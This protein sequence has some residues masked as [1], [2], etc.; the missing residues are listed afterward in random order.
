MTQLAGLL[1]V[2]LRGIGLIASAVVIGGMGYCL[3]VLRPLDPLRSQL[4][5]AALRRALKWVMGAALALAACRT[6]AVLVLQPWALADA[7]GRWPIGEFLRTGYARA[8]LLNAI[9]A[10]ALAAIVAS[11][12]RDPRSLR[13]WLAAAACAA[14]LLVSSAWLTHA[15]SRVEGRAP[16]MA[17]TILHAA[18]A[19]LWVGGLIHLVVFWWLTRRQPEEH[20]FSLR[21]MRRFSPL[22][23]FGVGLLLT[24]GLF[25]AWRYI[26]DWEALIG[27]GY[28]VMVLTKVLLLAAALGLGTLNF[29][30]V[31]R[32]ARAVAPHRT[33]DRIRGFI[34]A[35]VGIGVTVL[36]AA[37]AFASL[38]PAIDLND[39]RATPAE[40]LARF[41]PKLPRLASPPVGELL[42]VAGRIDDALAERQPEEYAWSEFNHNMAGLFVLAMG[43]CALLE[44]AGRARWARHWPL[45]FLGLAGF[46]FVRNDPRAWPLGPAGFWE[47]MVLPDVLQHR[48]AVVGVVALGL[49]EWSVRTDRLRDPH[50][51]Y[52]FPLLCA[53]SGA[54]LLTHSHAMFNLKAE[55]L[56]ELFHAPIGLL[57][58]YAGWGRWLELRLPSQD[59][60]VPGWVWSLAFALIGLLLLFYREG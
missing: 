4:R 56:A 8:A 20:E 10:L 12:G 53:A 17:G 32:W 41:S 21:V 24:P 19:F 7:D 33:P 23:M 59:Q 5:E 37:A 15:A 31:R 44:R 29:V 35:E 16:L 34:E 25:I 38:P 42:A 6:L 22:A 11:I 55:F 2:L 58:V 49:F 43:F 47:S 60:R 52:V 26:G 51:R 27:T 45:L 14:L 36:L 9:L 18:G 13:A 1:D 40:V 30:L 46:M 48:L 54:L 50:W 39:D 3:G 28:G 57:A